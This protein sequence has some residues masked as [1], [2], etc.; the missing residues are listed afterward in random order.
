MQMPLEPTEHARLVGLIHTSRVNKQF[1]TAEKF[2]RRLLDADQQDL[3]AVLL[4]ASVYIDKGEYLRARSTVLESAASGVTDLLAAAALIARLRGFS[5]FRAIDRLFQQLPDKRD[6]PTE[7]LLALSAEASLHGDSDRAGAYVKE[8]LRRDP[9]SP[10][11]LL[12]A[13]GLCMTQGNLGEAERYLERVLA[14]DPCLP[15]V[16]WQLSKLR[17]QTPENNHIG[18]IARVL[19]KFRRMDAQSAAMIYTAL[20]N[21]LNDVMD[22][23]SAWE[24]LQRA[25]SSKRSVVD[26]STSESVELV[27][28]LIKSN[29]RLGATLPPANS[30][31]LTPI[32]IV[33]MHR[34]GT[35]LVEQMIAC[36][37]E[38]CP[39]G[40]LYDFACAMRFAT[41]T[42]SMGP[43]NV[44]IA[45]KAHTIDFAKVG[46]SYL[47]NATWRARGKLFQTDKLPSNFLNIGYIL[48]ALPG[49][50]IIHMSRDP[51]ETCFSNLRELFSGVNLYAYRMDELADY[52]LQYMR[53]ME[54]WNS[55]H[56]DRILNVKYSELVDDP[57]SVMRSVAEFCGIAYCDEMRDPR[58]NNNAVNTASVVQV[59]S[60]VRRESK[61]KWAPYGEKLQPLI[62][63]LQQGGVKI[64]H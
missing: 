41:D 7:A 5:E 46:R 36:S 10:A 26:Y 35:T 42:P 8:A 34:S 44:G 48:H 4:L 28:E 33:G 54:H 2:C 58:N 9:E 23:D 51:V 63:R 57:E 30:G 27:D 43:V 19:Q 52:Y 47:D 13:G 16:Y 12:A 56:G 64:T 24:A 62:D 53:M 38:V 32:F 14:M 1:D 31:E 6:I 20:H 50:K 61:P 60:A 15:E 45:R 25:C 18:Q 22:F 59:R 55:I 37:P 11:S 40:E 49:A 29:E 3:E 39:G 21:E 17:K